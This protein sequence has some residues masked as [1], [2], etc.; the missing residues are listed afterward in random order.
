MANELQ[1]VLREERPALKVKIGNSSQCLRSAA[2]AIAKRA[3]EI[4]EVRGHIPGHEYEDWKSAEKETLQPLFCGILDSKNGAIVT[5]TRSAFG[6]VG[7]DIQEVEVCAESRRLILKANKPADGKLPAV[8]VYRV[9][10][11]ADGCDPS[12]ISLRL[13]QHGRFFE[14]EMR[15]ACAEATARQAA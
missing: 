14:I 4:Y 2:D 5:V 7:N 8:T 12:S 15:K 13:K 9:L 10:P 11:L 3:Y 6:D 1:G